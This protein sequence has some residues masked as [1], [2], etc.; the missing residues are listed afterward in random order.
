MKKKTSH[1]LYTFG[2]L[3]NVLFVLCSAIALIIFS[4]HLKNYEVIASIAD[5]LGQSKDA[6]KQI[7][8]VL[9]LLSL[10]HF[11]LGLLYLALAI[12]QKD[13][14]RKS[15]AKIAICTVFIILGILN[16]N[17]FYLIGGI[18]GINE[19]PEEDLLGNKP[20]DEDEMPLIHD[21]MADNV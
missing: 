1:T 16:V 7:F 3:F 2:F 11:L 14:I 5:G 12:R 9:S 4:H 13:H 20:S 8:N 19:N 10:V 6:V 17:A 18:I 21:P 15:N